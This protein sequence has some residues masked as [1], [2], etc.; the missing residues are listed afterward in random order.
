MMAATG[1][2]FDDIAEMS[3]DSAEYERLLSVLY[4]VTYDSVHYSRIDNK[5]IS[6]E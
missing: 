4:K 6:K 2:N 3:K 1:R 5:L